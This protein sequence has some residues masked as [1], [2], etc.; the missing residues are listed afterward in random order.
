MSSMS[1]DYESLISQALVRHAYL[2]SVCILWL[3]KAK[4]LST[5]MSTQRT[6]INQFTKRSSYRRRS[7]KKKFLTEGFGFCANLSGQ[8]S[9]S[10]VERKMLLSAARPTKEGGTQNPRRVRAQVVGFS[11]LPLRE[12]VYEIRPR[13]S[14]P[15]T[16]QRR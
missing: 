12:A 2:I 13:I 5:G 16:N 8:D 3:S 6:L 9:S 1:L 11:S 15:P 7:K 10:G 14:K 4:F